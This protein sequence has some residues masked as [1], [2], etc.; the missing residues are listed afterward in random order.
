MGLH[1]LWFS[2]YIWNLSNVPRGFIVAKNHN[3]KQS[4]S[5]DSEVSIRKEKRRTMLKATFAPSDQKTESFKLL[6]GYA[7]P[8]IG[9]GTWK[10]GSESYNSVFTAIVEVHM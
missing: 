4:T 6:S 5:C 9:L 7:I 2:M 1:C 8:A 10:S 3:H